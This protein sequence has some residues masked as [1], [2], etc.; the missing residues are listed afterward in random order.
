MTAVHGPDDH[1]APYPEP[2]DGRVTAV[3]GPVV[4]ATGLTRIR[5]FDVVRVGRERLPGEVIRLDQDVATIQVFEE[6]TGLRVG[7]PV[8]ATGSPL[9]ISLGPG[10][11]G[12]II[13]GTGRPLVALAGLDGTGVAHPFIQRGAD[14]PGLDG[15]RWWEVT[16]VVAVGAEV[17]EGDLLATLP[18]TSALE[19]RILLPP[20][21]AGTVTAVYPGPARIHDP[22]VEVDGKPVTM[23]QRWPV[24]RAR[25][26]RARLPLDRPLL[27]GT[28]VLDLLFPV[29]VGGAAVIPE[30][31]APARR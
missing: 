5:L 30:G 15:D 20:G 28:R 27:T 21:R 26:S 24:R 19:H 29:A 17:A 9:L 4:E 31:S 16:P 13:D 1:V 12:S 7:D 14:P 23:V 25:P 8:G 3:S 22:V 6:T 2:G 18:E 10:L 11:L